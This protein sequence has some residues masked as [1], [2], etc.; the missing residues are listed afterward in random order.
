MAAEAPVT[1]PT[2]ATPAPATVMAREAP[3]VKG[4]NKIPAP[5]ARPPNT[6][7]VPPLIPATLVPLDTLEKE[8]KKR[9]LDSLVHSRLLLVVVDKHAYMMKINLKLELEET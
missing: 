1:P 2:A 3:R 8:T 6:A 7:V 5:A 4:A 9:R